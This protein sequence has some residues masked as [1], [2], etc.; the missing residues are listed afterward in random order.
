VQWRYLAPHLDGVYRNT[1]LAR[2]LLEFWTRRRDRVDLQSMRAHEAGLTP[3]EEERFWHCRDVEEA[4]AGGE[5]GG[6]GGKQ[7]R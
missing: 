7:Q 2:E 6:R 4:H 3:Q 1:F 5:K